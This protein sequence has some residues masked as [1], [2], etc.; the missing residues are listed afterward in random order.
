[1]LSRVAQRIYWLGRYVERSESTARLAGVYSDLFLDL[2]KGTGLGWRTVLDINGAAQAFIN[3]GGD[4]DDAA[5]MVRFIIADANNPA[6]LFSSLRQARENARGT[7][8]IIPMEAWRLLNELYLQARDQLPDAVRQR[9]R[10]RILADVVRRCQTFNGLMSG[11]M[12]HGEAF[13]FGCMGTYLER[14]D[15]TTRIIDVAA[16]LLMSGRDELKPYD[17]TLWMAVLRSLSA[18]QMY[19]QHVRRRVNG[20]D[21]IR[22]LLTDPQFPRSVDY[23]LGEVRTAVK[24]LPRNEVAER[25]CTEVVGELGKLDADRLD[26]AKLHEFVDRL[27]LAFAGVDSDIFRT[28]FAPADAA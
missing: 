18:Y 26:P 7:R 27:Q 9:N 24:S 19:R 23:C 17:N 16:A 15:M 14:A 20:P 13:Q 1:M 8:D 25:R 21:V 3:S 10:R 12:S 5:D 11:T 4:P 22:F 28:W 2:P 6:S